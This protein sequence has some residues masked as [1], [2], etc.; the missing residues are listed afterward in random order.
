[1]INYFGFSVFVVLYK[2]RYFTTLFC[3]PQMA[4]NH[5]L[6]DHPLPPKIMTAWDN[7][8]R[9]TFRLVPYLGLNLLFA[10]KIS[11]N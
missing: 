7:G 5:T 8:K 9:T 2:W 3:L 1:M 4:I 6:L 11:D 10:N